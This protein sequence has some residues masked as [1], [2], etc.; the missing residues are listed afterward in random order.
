M[1]TVP[2]ARIAAAFMLVL[3]VASPLFASDWRVPRDFP[4]IQAANDS[5]DVAA[6]VRVLVGPGSFAGAVI[7]KPLRI[8][9]I[10]NAVIASGPLHPA[11]LVQGF[12]L[13]TGADGTTISHLRFKVDLAII[14]A[15]GHRVH[16]VAIYQ[17]TIENAVQ[18]I[19]AWL[20]SGWLITQN[21]II[22]LR[23]R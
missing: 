14:P 17:N 23:S 10:G 20:G 8:Q 7:N 9:G 4:T 11:G 5:P 18:G 6:G 21:D 12:R 22:D 15:T 2:P 16:N 13:M 19:S 1:T 3:G